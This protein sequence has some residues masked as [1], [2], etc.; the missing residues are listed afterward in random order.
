MHHHHH[1]PAGCLFVRGSFNRNAH[2]DLHAGIYVEACRLRLAR[3]YSNYPDGEEDGYT[4]ASEHA[5]CCIAPVLSDSLVPI[6]Q[7]DAL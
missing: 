4:H 1:L 5:A 2:I 3:Q 7:V 6:N